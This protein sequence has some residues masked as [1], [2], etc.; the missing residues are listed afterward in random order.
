[1]LNYNCVIVVEYQV[2][3]CFFTAHSTTSGCTVF[4]INSNALKINYGSP[5]FFCTRWLLIL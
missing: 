4:V 2:K 1:M 3:F 5:T